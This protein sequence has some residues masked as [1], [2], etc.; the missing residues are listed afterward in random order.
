MTEDPGTEANE[1][2]VD[3]DD[4]NDSLNKINKAEARGKGYSR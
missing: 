3:Q 1:D 4:L 2:I